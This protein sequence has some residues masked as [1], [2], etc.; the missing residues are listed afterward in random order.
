MRIIRDITT[1]KHRPRGSLREQLARCQPTRGKRR[2]GADDKCFPSRLPPVKE[3]N[4]C[5]DLFER[6]RDLGIKAQTVRRQPDLSVPSCKE[7]HP[8]MRFQRLYLLADGTWRDMQFA[9]GLLDTG[10]P[11]D[12]YKGSQRTE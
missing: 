12:F 3:L 10:L 4:G 7:L 1:A 8:E 5:V 11:T 9:G 2:H 6:W